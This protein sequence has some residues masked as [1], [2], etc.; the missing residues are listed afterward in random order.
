[1][2]YDLYRLRPPLEERRY[3]LYRDW[4]ESPCRNRIGRGVNPFM[5]I[6][7]IIVMTVLFLNLK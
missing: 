7:F 4:E 2:R 3:R 6:I 1:M 5:G